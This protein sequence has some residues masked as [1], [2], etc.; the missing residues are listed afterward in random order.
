MGKLKRLAD[1]NDKIV[2]I[3]HPLSVSEITS[4]SKDYPL[5]SPIDFAKKYRNVLYQPVTIEFQDVS[6]S[7]Q[8]NHCT[9][10]FCKWFGLEQTRFD[11][12][13][14]KPFRYRLSGSLKHASQSIVCNPDPTMSTSGTTWN[15][16]TQPLSNWS[17][18]EEISRLAML[19]KVKDVE[20][21]YE[22][23]KAGCTNTNTPFDK[24]KSFYSRGKNKANS[25]KWQCKTCKKMT[26]V[27]PKQRENFS[28]RQKRNDILPTFAALLLSRTP[29]KRTCEILQIGS[30]TYYHKLEWMYRKCLEFLERHE[31]NAFKSTTFNSM[32]INT[33]KMIY[34]LNNVRKRGFGGKKYDDTEEK[35]FQTHVVVSGE[36]RSRYIFRSDIAY[37]WNV[38][39][40]GVEEDTLL[41]FEDHL[42]EF[43]RKNGHLRFSFAPQPPSP[44]DTQTEFE[45]E[46]EL[47]DFE[48]RR[49]YIDGLHVN[50]TYTTIAHLWLIKKMIQS[51][52]WRFVTDQDF[53]I[54]RSIFRVFAKEVRLGNAHHFLCQIDKSNTLRDAFTQY[55]DAKEWLRNWGTRK[56]YERTS[57]SSLAFLY[58]SELFQSYSFHDMIAI[59]G[60]VY[61]KWG[62]QPIEHPLPSVDQGTRLVDCTTDLSSFE[63]DHIARMILK[64]DDRTTNAFMQQIRRRLSI[65]E[66]P[67]TTARGDGKSYIYTNFNPKYAQYALTILRTYYNFCMT[68]KVNKEKRLTPAQQIGIT[69]KKFTMKDI[70]YF[71]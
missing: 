69:D 1:K 41:Y 52:Q 35:L 34:H 54:I 47:H 10:P 6:H 71:K 7:I 31:T 18:A 25:Q 58:L 17:V 30:E 49:K 32:W 3:V 21:E 4:R 66:R 60:H 26:N 37:D 62:K 8:V 9:D 64:V 33:D 56:G 23:H 16:T 65:L 20:P 38:T 5:L 2:T 22:F 19:D 27:L 53:S 42:N 59:D 15:C 29:V 11:K 13:K 24:S 44:N 57:L 36:I 12:V 67:L 50:S 48:R 45:Y 68:Y 14:S 40:E 28:Y 55:T 46:K 51:K 39:L 70:I 63:P 43:A 61:P